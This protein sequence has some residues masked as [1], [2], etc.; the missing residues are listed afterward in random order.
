[1][2]QGEVDRV[3]TLLGTYLFEE[4][5][6]AEVEPLARAATVRHLD[7]D[8]YVT[9]VGD[10]ADELWVVASG[11]LKDQLVTEDGDEVVHMFCGPGMVLGEPGFFAPER[12]RIVAITAVEPTT[13][14]VLGRTAL[15]PFLRR[16]PAVV[17]RVIEGLASM[18]RTQNR[19]I[20]ALAR[21][22]LQ[23]RL[24]LRLLEL[25]ETNVPRE[26]GAVVTPK[27]SQST[28]AAMVGVSRENAN[29]ALA[30]LAAQGTIQIE[31]GRYVLP[32]PERLRVDVANGGPLLGWPNR[33]SGETPS[34]V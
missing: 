9:H 4:L 29:R 19:L 16:H 33:R 8:E 1:M 34:A 6:P 27:I 11:Q 10:P 24:V 14:L 17:T 2:G 31:S 21:R 23:A 3:A 12:N 7:R 13:L 32:D 5:S 22:P 15:E 25:A 28:L 26:D 20:V 30:A 18:T